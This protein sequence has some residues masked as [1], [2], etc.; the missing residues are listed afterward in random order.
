MGNQYDFVTNKRFDSF[1]NNDFFHLRNEVGKNSK[2]LAFIK[3]QLVL[4]LPLV[5]VV[6]TI[7]VSI[8]NKVF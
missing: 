8:A 7:L 4:L 3:G 2:T 6:L 5:L 1:V